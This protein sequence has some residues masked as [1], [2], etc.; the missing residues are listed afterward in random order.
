MNAVKNLTILLGVFFL[1]NLGG[2]NTPALVNKVDEDTQ[3][4]ALSFQPNPDLARVYFVTGKMMGTMFNNNHSYPADIIINSTQIGSINKDNVLYF[5]LKPGNYDFSWAVRNTDL[6]VKQTVP[7]KT[8]FDVFPGQVLVLRGDYNQG[9]S[10]F[11]LLGAMISPPTSV[12]T[13]AD[14]DEARSKQV[15]SPQNCDISLCLR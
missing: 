6:I 8:N 4:N 15:V 5:Q 3:K 12:I 10:T 2:C 11:G 1:I 7:R 14:R 13:I 9:G